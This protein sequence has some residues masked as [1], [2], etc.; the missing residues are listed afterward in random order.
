MN[1]SIWWE[2]QLERDY[3]YLLEIDPNVIS[4][5][6]QPFTIAYDR[7]DKRR[8]YTPDFFVQRKGSKQ[9]VEVKPTSKVEK[10]KNSY[11]FSQIINFCSFNDLEFAI[12]TEDVIRV[13]P[14]LSN[15]KLLYKYAK[16]SIPWSVYINCFDYL[17]SLEISTISRAEENLKEKGVTQS[18]LLKLL[19]DG[20]LMTDLMQSI[21]VSSSIRLS[22]SAFNWQIGAET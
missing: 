18:S 12:L 1:T 19:W 7:Y 2:S 9:V 11:R 21:S 6:G 8:K 16:V 3:I 14:R 13:Q 4:Y 20:F 10:F 15:V 22:P 17:Y 5:Q